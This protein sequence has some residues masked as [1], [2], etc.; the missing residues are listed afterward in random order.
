MSLVKTIFTMKPLNFLKSL[1]LGL[2]VAASATAIAPEAMAFGEQEVNQSAFIAVAIPYNYKQYRLEIIEQLPGGQQCWQESATNPA[3][4]QLLLDNFDH[5]DSCRRISNTNGYTLRIDGQDDRVARI[6][7]IVPRNGEL[8]LVAFHKDPT[9]PDLVIGR[10]AGISENQP[11]K[12]FFNPGWRITKRVHQGQTL[13]HVYISGS[14]FN[15][16]NVLTP[17]ATSNTY[18]NSA[19]ATTPGIDGNTIMNTVNHLYGTY[20]DPLLNSVIT[21]EPQEP[22]SNH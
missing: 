14:S 18:S 19:P 16:Q 10:T 15:A 3:T 4:V 8:Q 21:N 17:P 9:Q 7:K 1:F 5:T 2:S 6:D 22:S 11:L 12:V 13:N 20:V